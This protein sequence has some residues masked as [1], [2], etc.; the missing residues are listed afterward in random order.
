MTEF[1]NPTRFSSVLRHQLEV[2]REQFW[3]CI[4]TQRPV[5]RPVEPE[6]AP[7]DTRRGW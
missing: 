7:V 3:E 5:D 6:E 4:R 1:L 2:S